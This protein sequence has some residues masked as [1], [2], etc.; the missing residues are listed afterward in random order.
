VIKRGCRLIVINFAILLPGIVLLELLFGN[1]FNP[2]R[3]NRL[4][5]IR[6]TTIKYD[7]RPFY[8]TPNHRI[9]YR[10]DVFGLRGHYASPDRI[11]ILTIGGSTTDQRLIT[12]GETWQDVLAKD[13]AARGKNVNVVNA[14]VDGQSTYGHIKDFDWWFPLIPNLHV[15]YFLFYVGV[16][17]LYLGPETSN[18]DFVH[19]G[20]IRAMIQENSIFYYFYRT[21]YGVYQAAA[22]EVHHKA[23][24]FTRIHWTDIS[25]VSDHARLMEPR[26]EAYRARLRMLA[27]KVRAF[28]GEPICVTQVLR[29]YKREGDHIVGDAE[30][31]KYD[32]VRVNGVDYYYMMQLLNQT[33][34]H[35][36]EQ[37][38][39]VPINLADELVFD[40]TDFYDFAHNT[41]KGAAKIGHY[42]YQRLSFISNAARI[43]PVTVPGFASGAR[44]AVRR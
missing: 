16:N 6:E 41:P 20:V 31:N 29:K 32:G 44:V 13:F 1:W 24:P 40:D 4:N 23:V 28:G 26:I 5:L 34:L 25:L 3:L 15:R 37:M 42:L 30:V 17:D 10:R 27:L 7:V 22:A 14:G 35:E 9:V 18:E 38:G 21:L 12:E 33:T 2:R 11:D 19:P 36:C 39:G 8:A 43:G